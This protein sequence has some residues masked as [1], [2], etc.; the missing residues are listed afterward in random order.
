MDVGG[1]FVTLA[2]VRILKRDWFRGF[3]CLFVVN[4]SVFVEIF[5]ILQNVVGSI[6]TVILSYT[7]WECCPTLLVLRE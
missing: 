3:I 4:A 7:C 2:A 1:L 6:L 5:S